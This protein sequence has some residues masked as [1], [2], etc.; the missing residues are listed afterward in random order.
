MG[1]EA[2]SVL[3]FSLST[4]WPLAHQIRSSLNESDTPALVVMK[5]VR[6]VHEVAEDPSHVNRLR[7]ADVAGVIPGA[8][9]AYLFLGV[10]V[11]P[12]NVPPNAPPD[13]RPQ[14]Q[15]AAIC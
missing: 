3:A 1:A 6:S 8:L 14:H 7:H 11:V 13:F 15:R 2:P 9:S 12:D 5:P 10:P 4:S